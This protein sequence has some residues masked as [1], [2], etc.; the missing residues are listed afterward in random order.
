MLQT[1]PMQVYVQAVQEEKG[2]ASGCLPSVTLDRFWAGGEMETETRVRILCLCGLCFPHSPILSG[3][4]EL[5]GR[6]SIMWTFGVFCIW[7]VALNI[8][9]VS[10]YHLLSVRCSREGKGHVCLCGW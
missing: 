1:T 3:T 4:R 7:I 8:R 9:M 2:I 10:D 5:T 6:S